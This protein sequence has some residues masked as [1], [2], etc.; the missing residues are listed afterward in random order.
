[1]GPLPVLPLPV[2]ELQHL[3]GLLAHEREAKDQGS[4]GPIE[5]PEMTI[6][7]VK[8]DISVTDFK[9][10]CLDLIRRVERTGKPLTIKRRGKTVARL[11]PA[12]SLDPGLKPWEQLRMLGGAVRA[13]PG[14]SVIKDEDF[15]S[16]R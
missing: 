14:E 8:M 4:A 3:G 9:A 5:L 16:L 12:R 10:R 7:D 6:Y 13:A 11:E 1:M 15:E 2:D